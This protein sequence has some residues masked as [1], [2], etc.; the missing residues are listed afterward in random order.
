M[1]FLLKALTRAPLRAQ[2][3]TAAVV[4]FIA[5]HVIRWR[6]AQ[7]ERDIELAFPERTAAE[8]AV[9]LR[10]SYRNAADMV[11]EAVWGFGASADDF[12][13][14][15]AFAN[16]EVITDCAAAGRSAVLLTAHYANWEWLLLAAGVEFEIPIHVVYQPLRVAAVD[17]FFRDARSRFGS[18]LVPRSEFIFELMTHG[19]K[20]RAYALIADQTPRRQDPKHWTT[21]LHRDTA[22]FV[23]AGKIARFVDAQVIYVGMERLQRGRYSVRFT[24]LAMPPHEDGADELIVERYARALEQQVERDPTAFL[25]LQKRWKYAKPPTTS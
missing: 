21:F 2:Y 1:S 19:E 12:R 5:F 10:E 4:Y 14:R 9:I 6:R 23:G 15:V 16:P 11:M 3:V 24:V 13:M 8:R 25:W 20:P 18:R 7:T 17:T 22:F